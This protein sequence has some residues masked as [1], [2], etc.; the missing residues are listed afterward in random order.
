MNSAGSSAP[1]NTVTLTFPGA[2][3]PPAAP[4]TFSAAVSGRTIF[5]S[6]T[7]PAAG[8][9]A[10]GYVLIVTGALSGSVSTTGWRSQAPW[11][12]AAIT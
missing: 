5:A 7:P 2:C 1:P 4:S 11:R 10:T 3:V 9:A 12:R 6:W 8:P